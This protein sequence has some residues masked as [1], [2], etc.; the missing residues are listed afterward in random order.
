MT[1]EDRTAFIAVDVQPGF[2]E[3]GSLA[4]T[5]G[6][7][8]AHRIAGHLA[9]HAG[10]YDLIVATR[11]YHVDPG[12]HFGDP[13]DYRETWPVHCVAGTPEAELHP[14]LADAPFRQV[15]D[16]GAYAA[17]YSGFEASSPEGE[18]LDAYLRRHD[19]TVVEVA[20]LA[21]D[22]CVAATARD[23]VDLGYR[24]RVLADLA[25]GVAPE[26]A[27]AALEDLEARGVEV[28]TSTGD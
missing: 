21:T 12:A 28:T 3:G 10:D 23:A 6:N 2:C 11:D 22:Y 16:K 4:V 19:I 13:P 18:P 26:T 7:E 8:V 24:T 9:D 5:G 14:G 1:S 27:T 20:G 25:A 17:A 15:F